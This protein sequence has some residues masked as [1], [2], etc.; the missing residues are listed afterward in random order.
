MTAMPSS[1]DFLRYSSLL[2]LAPEEQEEAFAELGEQ[3]FIRVIARAL[4]VM[5]ESDS[6]KL[7]ALLSAGADGERIVSFLTERVPDLASIVGEEAASL[8][9][10]RLALLHTED[11]EQPNL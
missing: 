9:E 10:A 4:A 5:S 11:N 3:L 6:E 2:S 8:R 7:T 1:S